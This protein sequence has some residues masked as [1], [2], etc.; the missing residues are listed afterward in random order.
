[1]KQ[2]LARAKKLEGNPLIDWTTTTTVPPPLSSF[3]TTRMTFSKVDSRC[4]SLLG[5]AISD[6]D[7][8]RVQF[9][10]L[11]CGRA[12]A[13]PRRSQFLREM[14]QRCN[15]AK[16]TEQ[17]LNR[18]WPAR[19]RENVVAVYTTTATNLDRYETERLTWLSLRQMT[20]FLARRHT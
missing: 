3:E 9:I 5:N 7:Y 2:L 8:N 16:R 18:K 14:K 1:M 20:P 4:L 15:T 13:G 6:G 17:L 12:A 19:H 10:L 11:K